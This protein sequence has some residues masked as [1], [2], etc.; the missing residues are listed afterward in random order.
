MGLVVAAAVAMAL[1]PT[2][3]SAAPTAT[4]VKAFKMI[5]GTSITPKVT[6]QALDDSAKVSVMV[7]LTGDPVA[8]VE[9]KDGHQLSDSASAQV[10]SRLLTKQNALHR[11]IT[12]RGGRIVSQLQ[13]A[14]NGIHVQ[15]ARKEISQLEKLPNVQAV[16]ILTPKTLDTSLNN[17]V[18]IPY[19]DVPSVWQSTGFTGKHVKVAIIDTGID[20]THADFQGPGTAAAYTAAHKNSAKAADPKLFGP[21]APRVKGG[22]DFAGDDYDASGDNGSTVPKPDSN[23]LDCEGHGSHVAGSAVGGGVSSNGKAYTGPYNSSTSK[24]SFKVGPGV[25]P[26]ADIY[27]LKVFGCEGSTDLD[28]EAIDWVVKHKMNVINMSLG[29]AFG[30]P[31][32]PGAVAASNAVAA[33]VVVAASAGNEGQNPYLTGSPAAGHGVLSVSA[34]DSTATFPGATLKFG[35]TSLQ[36]IN[37]TGGKLLTGSHPIVVLKDDPLTPKEDESL[38]CSKEAYTKA[39]AAA[40]VTASQ[41]PIGVATRGTCARVAKAIYGE[42]AGA[43][44]VIMINT[45][46]SYPPYEGAVTANPDDGT[47]FNLTIPFLGIR[48]VDAA[49]LVAGAGKSLTMSAATLCN[50]GYSTYVSFS[51]AGP[52][53]GTSSLSPNIS[54]PGVSISSVAVGTGSGSTV[55]S[56]T[57]MASPHVAGVAALAVQ[58]HPTWKATEIAAAMGSTAN[59]TRVKSY[60]PLLGGGL[61]NAPQVVKTTSFAEGDTY[62]TKAGTVASASLSFG[63]AESKTTFTGSKTLTVVNKGAKAVTYTLSS[64]ASGYSRPATVSFS[65]KTITVKARSSAKVTVTLKAAA[66]KAGSSVSDTDLFSFQEISGNVVLSTRGGTLRVPY[67][68]VPR[69]QAN[70]KATPTGSGLVSTTST[71]VKG[72][73][74]RPVGSKVNAVSATNGVKLTNAG[75]AL[76][77]DASVFTWGLYDGRYDSTISG[78][79]GYDLRAAGVQTYDAGKDGKLLVFA[80]NNWD[81]YSNAAAN[82]YDVLIDTNG[83]GKSD[84]AVFTADYGAK[85]AGDNDGVTRVFIYDVA[86]NQ[87]FLGS[88][89]LVP[90]DSSTIE[91]PVYADDLGLTKSFRYTVASY[92]LVSDGQDSFGAQWAT[93]DP[94]NPAIADGAS[95][96]IGVNKSASLSISTDSAQLAKQNPL[97]VMVVSYENHSGSAEAQLLQREG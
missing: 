91:I 48:K 41:K 68:L 13:S 59:P 7:Q 64:K 74:P 43:G 93:Y 21:K 32:D 63:F 39:F 31:N 73:A 86:A 27:S 70:L 84:Y 9:A 1:P 92:S 80:V 56:G 75:G 88:Y 96:T 33:G 42:Q 10:R 24:K 40:G 71:P 81:R 52:A 97:G 72:F 89:A 87:V 45:D 15:I 79:N 78:G 18:S 46:D 3:A 29:S 76:P 58:A 34:I 61:V 8:V 14:Y 23:P 62:K 65:K 50:P 12:A 90:T 2:T 83:D 54:A 5:H 38:G 49:A 60:E 36:A 47:P 30:S 85:T 16:H 44:A 35:S 66:S 57:S 19:L 4:R 95:G 37:A 69:A 53:T 26:Q 55:M 22:Y 77:A 51:S 11:D 25:A 82:E 20:Y 17:T 6:P 28:T 94:W 67:L